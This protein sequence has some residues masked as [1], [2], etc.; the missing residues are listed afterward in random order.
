MP[1]VPGSVLVPI[2][3][4]DVHATTLPANRLFSTR[5][6]LTSWVL[7]LARD[8]DQLSIMKKLPV[9]DLLA[10]LTSIRFI[11]PLMPSV[12]ASPGSYFAHPVSLFNAEREE[13]S[14]KEQ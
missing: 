1:S 6:S 5:A 9:F 14:K 12:P 7:A 4:L 2:S 13:R 3:M 10:C 11:L 8:C